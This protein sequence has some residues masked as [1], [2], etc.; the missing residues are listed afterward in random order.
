MRYS[1]SHKAFYASDIAPEFLPADARDVSEAERLAILQ[2]SAPPPPPLAD[3]IDDA[4][5]KI[6][7][8]VDRIYVDT[9]GNRGEEYR[10][11]EADAQ[12]YEAAG[13]SGAVPPFVADHQAAKA[14]LGWTA[15]Q[16]AEDILATAANWRGAQAQIRAQRLSSKEQAR[17]AADSAALQA[18]MVAWDG[19]VVTVRNSLG[20]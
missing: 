11:A 6:D 2:A 17:I 10:L 19:F 18:V 3:Q 13:F 14:H 1:D 20:I 15:Q 16:A 12:A 5:R 4:V 9:I 7:R 8:D